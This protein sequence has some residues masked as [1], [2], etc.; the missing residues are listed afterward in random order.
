MLEAPFDGESDD[1]E[2]GY[3]V[4]CGLTYSGAPISTVTG[5]G[6]LEGQSVKVFADGQAIKGDFTVTSGSITLPSSF[7]KISVGL[8]FKSRAVTLP[9]AGPGQDGYLFGRRAKAVSAHVDVLNSGSLKVGAFGD[10][11]WTP[12]LYEQILQEGGGLF[13]APTSLTT[14]FVRCD[15][16]S[17]WAQGQGKIVMETDDPLPLLIRAVMLQS[18]YEP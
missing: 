4:D 1:I 5:L 2:D 13:T 3:F 7:S 14:G 10:D 12:P 18:E 6:H 17:S 15:F 9:I 11:N 16:D 8:G